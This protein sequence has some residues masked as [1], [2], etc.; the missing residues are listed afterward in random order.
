M[1]FSK[2]HGRRVNPDPSRR[3]VIVWGSLSLVS[4]CLMLQGC[5]SSPSG[6]VRLRPRSEVST[7]PLQFDVADGFAKLNQLRARRGLVGF[8]M[9]PRL[10]EAAQRH[11]N[12]MGT[13]GKYGHDIGR[14]TDFKTRIFSAGFNQSAGENIGVGYG[15]VDEAIQGWLKS[16]GHRKN[17]LKS[18]YTLA[19]LAYAFNTSG[20]ND[21]YTHFWVLIMGSKDGEPSNEKER[22]IFLRLPV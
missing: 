4:G 6:D 5:T 15:S 22:P 14:G 12:L 13:T 17:M 1:K 19:G 2:L 10:Q 8:Q 11:A 18:R 9:D 3:K 21:R 20:R 16:P 7:Q